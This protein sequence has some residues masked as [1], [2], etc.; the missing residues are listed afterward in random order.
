[1]VGAIH[2]ALFQPRRQ[3]DFD[4]ANV[5]LHEKHFSEQLD[6]LRDNAKGKDPEVN[7]GI[8]YG[9]LASLPADASGTIRFR[10]K[11]N[12]GLQLILK[13]NIEAAAK[14]LHEAYSE[15]P[16][17]PRAIANRALALWLDGNADEAYRYG[18]DMLKAD[19][20][21]EGLAAY[22]VQIA[23]QIP[24]VSDGLEEVPAS[25]RDKESIVLGQGIFLRSRAM[26]P[27]WWIWARAAA[28]RF[29]ESTDLKV[30]AATS[31]VDE[32]TQD[33]EIVRTQIL[34][35]DQQEH[36]VAAAEIL[37][38]EWQA[39]PWLLKNAT[40]DASYILAN[41][42]I[43]FS[44]LNNREAA[45]RC[46]RRIADEAIDTPAI[47]NNAIMTA[48]R[49]NDDTLACKLI[50]LAPNDPEIAFHAGI[51]AV[52]EGDWT[53]A[54]VS[55]QNAR[56]PDSETRMVETVIA[57][58]PIKEKGPPADGRAT[59]PKP[60]KAL[61]DISKDNPRG[62]I[63]I[64][65]IAMEL[66]LGWLSDEALSAAVDAVPEESNLVT[67][68][69]VASYAERAGSPATVIRLLDGHLPID[70]FQHEH[71]RL[72]AAHA[73]EHPHRARNLAYFEKLPVRLLQIDEIAR[74][75]ASVLLDVGRVPEATVLLKRLH[76]NDPTDTYVALRL[77]EALERSRDSIGVRSIVDGLDLSKLSGPP[78]YR[79]SLIRVAAR[80]G[81]TERIF[82][83][84]YALVQKYSN[85]SGVVLGY[86]E[87]GLFTQN[88][89]SVF[90]ASVAAAGTWVNVK[91]PDGFQQNFIID[92]G[93]DFFGIRTLSPESS[94]A[95]LV[96]GLKV[97]EKFEVDKMGRGPEEWVI[98]EIKSKYL[99]LFH[100]IL[101]EYETRFPDTPGIARFTADE[102]NIESVLEV[103]RRSAEISSKVVH[104]YIESPIPLCAVARLL[105]GNVVS[106]AEHVR[107]LGGQIT[108]CDG[109]GGER[110]RGM[111]LAN[112]Y[113]G[114]GAI[115]DPYTAW[116]AAEIDLLPT[117]K[118][119]FEKLHTPTSTVEM[120]DKM[121]AHEDEGRGR[122]QMSLG[123]IEGSYFRE[124]VTDDLRDQ[125][126]NALEM[127]K[128]RIVSSCDA[129]R[130]LI[131]NDTSES[132]ETFLKVW[133][134]SSFDAAFLAK[135]TGAVLISDDLRYRA[136]SNASVGCDAVW[137]QATLLSALQARQ[138]S[139]SEY[140]KFVVGLAKHAH[141]HVALSG[142]LLCEIA[143]SDDDRFSGLKTALRFFAGSKADMRSHLAVFLDYLNL[144]WPPSRRLPM[145]RA[146]AATGHGLEAL[147]AKRDSDFWPSIE[148]VA[149][150]FDRKSLVHEYIVSWVRGHFLLSTPPANARNTRAQT[151]KR[152]TPRKR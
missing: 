127:I 103:V 44:L 30:L 110:I 87:L 63:L 25:L 93:G 74:A 99:H 10:A 27:A 133:G 35:I 46:A 37:D 119:W 125:R 148:F 111:R 132:V 7:L 61:I 50:A 68:L 115:L 106:F 14:S 47:L 82:S 39:Q 49:F 23:A 81:G 92:D 83:A 13:G 22:L 122:P 60:L 79:M 70:G 128:R 17:D 117:L 69:M 151:R 16:H 33:E 143:R 38:T 113:R 84:A 76:T 1:M 147:R 8:F 6:R 18:R 140:A 88:L 54:A 105:G 97:G 101:N 100:C 45:L 107:R 11:A 145:D 34:S 52:K 96:T 95:K 146:A 90:T 53:R 134:S 12:I 141:N 31:F 124:E 42:M 91:A 86:A 121:I 55:F 65:Q 77:V 36:L 85:N 67:R 129:T 126:I 51:I 152:K 112:R 144:L 43:A 139:I 57:L 40:D 108:T 120:I 142:P 98:D 109:S 9:F 131:P 150:N 4:A 59:D 137:L 2:S 62:L 138:F 114:K 64:A 73:R 56:I 32:V 48:F 130:V 24:Q 3:S 28:D 104:K 94:M 78:D 75:H 66:G 89:E 149:R 29:P 72:A 116:V 80:E 21:N 71:A 15:A 102:G 20:T 5:P 19:P 26:R 135:E 41:A 118:A 136:I 58:A 123:W